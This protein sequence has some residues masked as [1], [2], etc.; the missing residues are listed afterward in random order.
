MIQKLLTAVLVSACAVG[1]AQAAPEL[2]VDAA[3]GGNSAK[4]G[5]QKAAAESTSLGIAVVDLDKVAADLGWQTRLQADQKLYAEQLK[6]ELLQVAERYRGQ[7]MAKKEAFAPKATDPLSGE[8]RQ[9][10]MGMSETYNQM[11]AQ[12]DQQAGQ[13]LTAYGQEKARRYREALMPMIKQISQEKKIKLV[14]TQMGGIAYADPEIDLTRSLIS[15]A[16]ANPPKVEEPPMSSLTAPEELPTGA[17]TT[18][19]AGAPTRP[20]GV[21]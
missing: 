3:T 12:L 6:K 4:G 1:V 13:R 18:Q 7:I 8:Q 14:L 10:L 5:D 20:T 17:P 15:A 9:T 21:P 16:R 2:G 19:P 11:L